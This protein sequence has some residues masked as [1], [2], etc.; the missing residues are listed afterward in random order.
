MA[1]TMHI[2]PVWIVGITTSLT[3]GIFGDAVNCARTCPRR[4]AAFAF[5]IR[6]RALAGFIFS[7]AGRANADLWRCA[8]HQIGTADAFVI[9]RTVIRT[10]LVRRLQRGTRTRK[11]ISQITASPG[12]VFLATG[13]FAVTGW[14]GA[15]IRRL[16]DF[17]HIVVASTSLGIRIIHRTEVVAVRTLRTG[18]FVIPGFNTQL[19]RVFEIGI[20]AFSRRF[21]GAETPAPGTV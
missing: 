8:S 6:P 21:V 20:F 11:V 5:A 18:M 17:G 1:G 2:A 9:I 13:I 3:A 14:P 10:T 4:P 19:R 15:V 7:A 12:S 16:T